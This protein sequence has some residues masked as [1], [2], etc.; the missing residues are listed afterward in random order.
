MLGRPYELEGEVVHGHGIGSTKT[1]PTLNLATAAEVLP[2]PGVFITR[3]RDLE[4][5]RRWH[6]ITN[7]G[8]RPTFG[9]NDRLSIE[10]FLLDPLIGETPSRIS[11]EL[12]TRVRDEKKF[13]SPEALKAQ[14]MRDVARA[15]SYFRRVSRS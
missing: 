12:L 13:E 8:Y 7:V 9:D 6:S 15:Q 10:T 3:T 4:D 1:V 5:G 11:V 14:I 2:K